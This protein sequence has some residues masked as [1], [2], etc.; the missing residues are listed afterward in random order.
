MRDITLENVSDSDR[1]DLQITL[2]SHPVAVRPLTIRI[3]RL[4]A[5]QLHR[6]EIPDIQLDAPLLARYT[7]A[8]PLELTITVQ[9]ATGVLGESKS[10]LRLLPPSH[11]GGGLSAPE[12][13]AA[14]IR[15]N[16][17]AIDVILRDAAGKLAAAKRDT[18]LSGY[19]G[20]HK[21]RVWEIAESIWAALADRRIAYVL[22]PASFERTGQKIR[23]P[24]DVLERKVGTCLD[25]SLLYAAALEQAGLN[26]IV[27][28]TAGHAFLGIWLKNEDFSS[29][30]IDDMQ[31]LRKRRDLEDVIFVETTLLAREPPGG[32]SAAVEQGAR[33]LDEPAEAPLEVAVD[34]HRCRLRGIHPLALGG[35]ASPGIKPANTEALNQGLSE[36]PHFHD[37]LQQVEEPDQDKGDRLERWKRKLLDLTL[38]NKLLN[39]KSGKNSIVI[40][41]ADAALLEDGL[42]SGR[43]FKVMPK[44][45]VLSDSDDRNSEIF[46]RQGLDDGR[47]RYLSDALGHNEIYS[48]LT[49][50]ELEARL[51]DLFRLA[52]NGFEE[53]GANILFLAIG[54]LRWTRKEGE[55]PYRA[56]LLL[57]PVSLKRSSVRAGFRLELHDD[58]PRFN[59]TL[60]ELLRQ[61]FKLRIPQLEGELPRDDAGLDVTKIFQTVRLHVRDIKG[62]EVTPDVVLSAFSFTKYLMWRDL[63]DRAD[64]LK[65]N[66]V[67]RHLIETPTHSYHDGS[68]FPEPE[69][70]DRDYKPDAIFAPLSAD[71]SQLSAVLAASAGKDF[72]LFGPPGTGKSQTIGNMIAQCLAQ[73]RSVLFV[74][75]KTAALEVVQRRLHEIGLSDY[76]LEIHSTKAQKSSVLNQLK[77][78]WHERDTPLASDWNTTAVELAALRDELN[79][80]V[81][82]LH[83]QRENGLS[84]YSA[85]GRI[86]AAEPHD[87]KLVL[88]WPDHLTHSAE[89]LAQFRKLCRDLRPIL[90]SVG[91]IPNHPLKGIGAAEWS[92]RWQSEIKE[93][94]ERYRENLTALRDLAEPFA[95]SI[96][97]AFLAESH[98]GT[99]GLV[100]LASYLLKPEA[101]WSAPL[102]AP[103][104]GDV[105]AALNAREAFRQE[106]E[107]H[108]ARLACQYKPS[109]FD[110][111]LPVLLAEWIS[112]QS[113]N[114]LFRGGK[115]RRVRIQMALHAEG[116]LPDDLGPDLIC[117]MDVLKHLQNGCPEE[118]ALKGLGLPW[119]DAERT[120]AALQTATEW[121]AKIDELAIALATLLPVGF[122][123]RLHIASL[124]SQDLHLYTNDASK[125]LINAWRHLTGD[126][127]TLQTLAAI[128][129]PIAHDSGWIDHNVRQ[130]ERWIGSLGAAKAW[131]AWQTEAQEARDAGLTPLIEAIEDGR[132]ASTQIGK[133]FE[134]AYARWW[135]DHIVSDDPVL[136]RFL[137]QKHEDTIARFR[138]ADA[139]LTE[140]TKRV[141]RARLAGGIPTPT[142][143]GAD[144]EWGTLANQFTRRKGHM[145]LRKLFE[146]MPNVLTKL[147]PCIMMSPLSIAQYLP[148]EMEPFDIVIFDEASQISP[149]DAI[150]AIARGRQVVIVGDPEQLP[151][152][153]VGDRGVDDIEDGTDVADQESILDECLAAN[154]PR[155]NLDWHYRSRHESLIAFSNTR[156]YGGRLVTFPSPVTED[157]AVRLIHVSD[158]VYERGTSNRVNRPEA[159][160]V[161]AEIVRRLREPGFSK[162]S[163]SLGVVTFN[164]DQQRLIENLLDAERRAN[165]DL[166]PFFD[167]ERWRE[168]VFVKNLE[169]VQGDERDIIIFSVAVGPDASGRVTST[170]SSLNKEGGHRRLNVA[171]TRA[172]QELVVFTSLRP[173]Q[174]DLGRTAARGVRDFKHFLE[175]ADRGSRAIAEAFAPTGSDTESPFEDAVRDALQARGWV[176]HPQ[177][178]VSGFRI[179][180]GIVHPDAPGRYLAGVECDG[181]TYHRSATARDRDRLREMV[182]TGLGWKIRRVW[183]TEWWMDAPSAC[184][185]LDA[186]LR[187]DL[188][189]DQLMQAIII[190]PPKMTNSVIVDETEGS[191]SDIMAP[192]VAAEMPTS[193]LRPATFPAD[194]LESE[195]KRLYADRVGMPSETVTVPTATEQTKETSYV[196]TD[197]ND[198]DHTL[199]A[200][201]FYEFSYQPVLAAAIAHV[202]ATEAPLY[203]DVLIRRIARA[204]GFNR[205]GAKIAQTI[206]ALVDP[207]NHRTEENERVLLWPLG[208]TP[209]PIIPFRS[210]TSSVRSHADTPLAELA[211]LADR[212]RS[213]G[214]ADEIIRLLAL[215]LGLA[216]LEAT[217]RQRFEWAIEI[218]AL[219][220]S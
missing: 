11:W 118:T 94:L 163:M 188:A 152:T 25:L 88:A 169:N 134:T 132:I 1:A 33:H 31:L 105:M 114:I 154:I 215:E 185:R 194:I 164:A 48:L 208:T 218:A 207:A 64:I 171:V 186:Q 137:P 8:S 120:P 84:A 206:T 30:C 47:R 196:T 66:P 91:D 43:A 59:P 195:P 160:T 16:D 212:L 22:P 26:T 192:E 116:K 63:V 183:S 124:A 82:A 199:D 144:P 10:A 34:V 92:P 110:Q 21:A 69:R 101:L 211:G 204:H 177:V 157:R 123:L 96:G 149:W 133:A 112:A 119:S 39:F 179:D 170:V 49:E 139:R 98:G 54:F 104:N 121:I 36:P 77:K 86:V 76:S 167:K 146:K 70:L 99:R 46:I 213:R 129:L 125:Q 2:A 14:F 67:V 113:A 73:G 100:I 172:R 191:R 190:D 126:I 19:A 45:D 35:S 24:T 85:F 193:E 68:E 72:V 71:S 87:A 97:L 53:G 109:I 219:A 75:Q 9:D 165:P 50:K 141:V 214:R 62:W 178:G 111:D 83:R 78:A 156:Y 217:T 147:T 174:I 143:F 176:V 20:G 89:T 57:V 182:L 203:E 95:Q 168:P 187:A 135:I 7:E 60:I 131:C 102:L 155:R 81:S 151:P 74:S 166:E 162:A 220:R 210:A 136:R 41:C 56:P 51:L 13:L 216:R 209:A 108:A 198:F 80:L 65:R 180:L 201:R 150:G 107:R 145:P 130:T 61:D 106:T 127:A 38:R 12:L 3:E 202:I 93:N 5:K 122:D 205:S 197:F 115:T 128:D 52:R 55:T 189:S 15:P 158:G 40:E 90:E 181:A 6:V 173:E 148:A 184:E 142:A 28:L 79:G 37:D 42:S 27:I 17:P 200:D 4:A 138:D 58:E 175:Y 153:N 117:L 140:L 32:F 103:D 23:G 159:R 161:V 18:A 44:T 29:A